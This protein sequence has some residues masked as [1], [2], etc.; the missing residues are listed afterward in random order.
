[1]GEELLHQAQKEAI[2]FFPGLHQK[3]AVLVEAV[4]MVEQVALAV[5]QTEAH[6]L[7][8]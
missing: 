4:L 5:V 2:L 3:V 6:V 1:M 7:A 8:A